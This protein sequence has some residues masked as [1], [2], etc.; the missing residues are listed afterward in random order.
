[1]LVDEDPDELRDNHGRVR[2]VDL[3]DGILVEVVQVGS[4]CNG[5]VDEEL[6]RVRHHEVLLIDTKEPACLIGV[7]RIEEEREVLLHGFLVEVDGT[8]RHEAV[9][10]TDEVEQVEP[11]L[12]VPAVSQDID[13][14]E[15]RLHIEAAEVHGVGRA[16]IDEPVLLL[17]P[18]IRK[19]GLLVR[20]ELLMEEAVVVVEAHAVTRKAKRCDGVEEARSKTAKSAIAQRRLCLCF[21]DLVQVMACTEELVLHLVVDAK[22]DEV[23]RQKTANQELGGDVIE[24]ALAFRHRKLGCLLADHIHKHRADVGIVQCGKGKSELLVGTLFEIDHGMHSLLHTRKRETAMRM[25]ARI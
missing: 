1:M 9:I 19:L 14:I 17:E 4:T 22:I 24:T 16:G 12:R 3:D 18:L 10:D 6:C 20:D 5:I 2:I 15:L 21:L 8:R 13:I 7:V 11:V 25:D 23:V